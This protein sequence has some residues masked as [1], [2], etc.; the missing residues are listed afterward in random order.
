LKNTAIGT[1][2]TKT[3]GACVPHERARTRNNPARLDAGELPSPSRN[4]HQPRSPTQP[5]AFRGDTCMS[6]ALR[7]QLKR[8]RE[9]R[10]A[11]VPAPTSAPAPAAPS[12][13]VKAADKKKP[14]GHPVEADPRIIITHSCGH[15]TGALY[16]QG[17]PC[18]GC[19][20]RQRQQ[21]PRK[22]GGGV[23]AHEQRMQRLPRLPDGAT[24]AATYDAA[25]ERWAGT[26]TVNGMTFEVEASGVFRLMEALD[27]KYR[28][29]PQSQSATV[30][31]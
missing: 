12:P 26:L 31:G 2:G 17:S 8:Q 5:F 27:K 6:S 22:R 19:A 29:C 10:A 15:K 13:A 3:N 25:T 30:A 21:R 14:R 1:D 11:T 23:E 9:Q 20:R 16:L 4:G 24:F 7:D 28:K 18:A